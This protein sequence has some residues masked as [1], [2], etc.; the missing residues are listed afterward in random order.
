MVACL[1]RSLL[2]VPN[3]L[4]ACNNLLNYYK[5]EGGR[6]VDSRDWQV[7]HRYRATARG[8]DTETNK[9]LKQLRSCQGKVMDRAGEAE[10]LEDRLGESA[11]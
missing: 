6:A 2:L 4:C 7:F 10:A 3:R 5:G 9:I 11:P 1:P 8:V